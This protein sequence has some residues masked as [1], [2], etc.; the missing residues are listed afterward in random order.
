M[1][2]FQTDKNYPAESH[3]TKQV[4]KNNRV[5]RKYLKRYRKREKEKTSAL[6]REGTKNNTDPH[7][8]KS[9]QQSPPTKHEGKK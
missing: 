8:D 9:R 6:Q 3:Q 7:R 4:D 2:Y 1:S 5:E